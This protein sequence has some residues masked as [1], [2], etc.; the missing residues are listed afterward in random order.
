MKPHAFVAMPFGIKEDENKNKIDFNKIYENYIKPAVKEAGFEVF[1][2]DE[3]ER[4]GEIREDMFM[5]LLIADLVVVDLT[6]DNPNVWYE[7]GVRHALRARGVVLVYGGR[8]RKV[9]DVYT[10]RKLRYSLVDGQLNSETLDEDIKKL[11]TMIKATQDSWQGRKISPVFN[12]LPNLQEPEW[13]SIKLGNIGEIHDKFDRWNNKITLAAK[14]G[15]VGDIV[16]LADEAPSTAFRLEAWLKAGKE[17]RKIESYEFALELFE[18]ALKIDKDN[19]TLLK[20]KGICLQRLAIQEETNYSIDKARLHYQNL[21]E[22]Y[23]KDPEILALYARLDKDIWVSTWKNEE[24]FQK[25]LEIAEDEEV[26][27]TNAIENYNKAYLLDIRHYYSG[28]NTLTLMSLY[29]YLLKDD[30]YKEQID[31]LKVSVKL[32]SFRFNIF[33]NSSASVIFS[34]VIIPPL[35]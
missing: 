27:L 14:N 13:K 16:L 15:Y 6:I 17:L 32:A 26:Y 19:I 18:K 20:E 31:T 29:Q 11:T 22:K 23:P 21:L 1:R 5:E 7:L 35:I 9:F 3:E 33:F 12:L 34:I 24:D 2:A 10:D 25:R 4:A 30:T 8:S 28:I